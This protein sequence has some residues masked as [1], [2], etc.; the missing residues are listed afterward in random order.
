MQRFAKSDRGAQQEISKQAQ[1]AEDEKKALRRVI[2]GKE[3][4]QSEDSEAVDLSD[5]SDAEAGGTG[6]VNKRLN[7]KTV[8]KAKKL[9]LDEIKD[10]QKS[11]GDLPTTGILGLSFMRNAIR[12]KR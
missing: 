5:D 4:D 2:Q 7:Q 8:D 1:A 10:L 3:A 6:K 12:Q 11:E 9:T